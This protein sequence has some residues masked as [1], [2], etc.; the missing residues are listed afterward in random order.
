MG[1]VSCLCTNILKLQLSYLTECGQQPADIL[2]VLD[3]S[4]SEGPDNFQTMLTFV[5]NFALQFPIGPNNVQFSIVTF[6]S[7]VAPQFYFNTY[8]S[9]HG[10]IRAIQRTNYLG[11]GTNT[12]AALNFAR[13]ESFKPEHGARVNAS[14]IVIAITD[15]HSIDQTSTSKE[16]A[17]L[18]KVAEVFAIGVGPDVDQSEL[19]AIASGSGTSHIV[20]VNSFD[21]LKTIQKQLTDSACSGAGVSAATVVGTLQAISTTTKRH[22]HTHAT[23]AHHHHG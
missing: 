16:A 12:S 3:S 6:S 19:K 14:K 10:V 20:Q 11:T 1:A 23:K 15:G 22:H 13:T 8:N 4:D 17:E 5:K 9:R 21:L 7:D 2:F 18:Q